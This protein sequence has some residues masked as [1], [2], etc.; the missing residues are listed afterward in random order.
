MTDGITDVDLRPAFDA[1]AGDPAADH[2]LS[3]TLA[4]V[5]E[6]FLQQ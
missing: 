1:V 5:E 4:P 6:A 2:R 3:T